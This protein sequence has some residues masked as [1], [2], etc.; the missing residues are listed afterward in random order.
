MSS[1]LTLASKLAR[2]FGKTKGILEKKN[3]ARSV[4]KWNTEEI[5]L[6]RVTIKPFVSDKFAHKV[7]ID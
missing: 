3:K 6:N 1:K 4:Y 7:E 5:S 2:R